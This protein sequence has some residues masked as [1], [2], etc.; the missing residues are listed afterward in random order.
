MDPAFLEKHE[1]SKTATCAVRGQ[2][3]LGRM[4]GSKDLVNPGNQESVEAGRSVGMEEQLVQLPGLFRAQ[5]TFF[6]AGA[7]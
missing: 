6:C 2:E 1:A 3:L 5:Q 7:G 4:T